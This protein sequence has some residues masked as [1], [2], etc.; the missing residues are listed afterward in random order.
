MEHFLIEHKP[1]PVAGRFRISRSV[2]TQIDTVQVKLRQN[3]FEGHA[4]CR[5][6]ARYGDTVQSVTTQLK[7]LKLAFINEHVSDADILRKDSG[8]TFELCKRLPAGPARNA[9]DCALWDLLAKTKN[10][11]VWELLGICA[12]AARQTAYTL[13][14]NTPGHMAKAAMEAK[15]YSLLKIKVGRHKAIECVKAV[16]AARPDARLIIDANEALTGESLPAFHKAL[17]GLNIALIEQPLPAGED[18]PGTLPAVKD[19]DGFKYCAD[20][21]LHGLADLARLKAA[22]YRAVNVKLDKCGGVTEAITL[23]RTAKNMGF[24]VMAG[25]MVGSSLAMAPMMTLERLAD[26]I[27]LDG[28]LLLAQDCGTPLIY[29][30]SRVFPPK[31]ELWG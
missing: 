15:D 3:G 11:P 22:G 6:Y 31:Q 23:M 12:P 17:I 8:G 1:W 9:L 24:E 16:C 5:P 4:E 10:R 13:S 21:S 27:D 25:C 18:S 26:Y 28:P 7:T 20:E 19:T 29:D 2:L 30:G 14:L